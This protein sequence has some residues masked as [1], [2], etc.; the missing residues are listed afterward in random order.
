VQRRA[1]VAM[2]TGAP[3]PAAGSPPADLVSQARA[4]YERALEAQRAGDWA[5]YGEEIRRLG[6]VL[7]R[8]AAAP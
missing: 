4:H 8:L 7:S 6:D 5:R 3:A 2:P 1:T